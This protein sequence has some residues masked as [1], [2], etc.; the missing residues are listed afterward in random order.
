MNSKEAEKRLEKL[1][2]QIV[3]LRFRYHVENDPTVTDDV[4]ESLIREAKEI[5]KDFP[6]FAV[7]QEF[8]RVAG[9][10]LSVF[11]KVT[12]STRML[13]LN[14]VFSV[15]ELEQWSARMEKLLQGAT[16][17]Y[18]AEVKL[19]GLA[20]TLRYEKGVLVQAATRGD[21]LVGEDVTE[22]A[23]M[24]R[25]IPLKLTAPFPS[26][27][28]IRGEIIMF[29][30][31]LAKLN[32]IQ[33]KMGKPAFANTRNAAAGSIRQLDPQ[34][35]KERQLDF[36]AYDLVDPE[37]SEGL[38]THSQKHALLRAL[39]MPVVADE[40]TATN[41]SD[42]ISFIGSIAKKRDSLPFNIDGIVISVD[43]LALQDTLGIVG[44]A[45]RYTVAYKYPAERVT[46]A[47][48]DITVNVGRTGVL[49]PLAHFDP[50]VVA[51]STV[52]K[53]TLHN[54]DQ[55]ARLD[56]RIGD[57]V[58]IQKAGD[59]IPEVVQV[60]KDLRSGKEKKFSMPKK[61]PVCGFP[62]AQQRLSPS[63]K[64]RRTEAGKETVAFFCTNDDCP[65]KHTRGMIHFVNMLDIYEV[66]PKIIDRLQ[67]EG[68][69]ADAGDLFALTEADLSGLERLG[70]KSA[71][72]IIAAIAEKKNP[73]LDRFIA[74]L[75]IANVGVETARDIALHFGSFET[76]WNAKADSFESIPNIGP[77]VVESIDQYRC[78]ESSINL[79][80]KLFENGVRPQSLAPRKNGIFSNMTI[81]L[82]G[83]LMTLS[84]E[85]AK[86]IIQSQGGKVTGSV[87]ATT[88]MVIAGD[89][90]GSKYADAQKLGVKILSEEDFLKMA[91]G[92]V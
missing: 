69:I 22:N 38:Q 20:V 54:M 17:H 24:V 73:P 25:T 49:T 44:K 60:L 19:D 23:K 41:V 74:S 65:A 79:I 36:F 57:T 13:S 7:S 37:Q 66:G 88:S 12:H 33:A 29:K 72:N 6:Q 89:R 35:V 42:L 87:S 8:D 68:L 90:P 59:V 14:D 27:I 76:F 28:E 46:T 26:V 81:V 86:E 56:I 77:A 62:V 34:L 4:Y 82:T 58:I 63:L 70:E 45:P 47:V 91:K 50:V 55:I 85:K 80:K 2:Q 61:C 10:P 52:S 21:G 1:K 5:E 15:E 71:Q 67:E 48:T 92:L 51:G 43:E 75:G 78:R 11:T 53:A 31:T 18:F 64:L 39:G 83:T 16:H 9:A 84:R 40:A 32:A 3:D 30:N